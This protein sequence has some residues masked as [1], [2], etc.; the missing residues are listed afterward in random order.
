M[1]ILKNN[2]KEFNALKLLFFK[3]KNKMGLRQNLINI[4]NILKQLRRNKEILKKILNN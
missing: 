3:K 2:F 4:L 1:K